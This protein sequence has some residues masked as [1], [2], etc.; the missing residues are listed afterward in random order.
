MFFF[1]TIILYNKKFSIRQIQKREVKQSPIYWQDS[2][3]AGE[4]NARPVPKAD[5]GGFCFA[6]NIAFHFESRRDTRRRVAPSSKFFAK[7]FAGNRT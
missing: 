6:K 5:S 3:L 4:R 2:F 1:N 7:N